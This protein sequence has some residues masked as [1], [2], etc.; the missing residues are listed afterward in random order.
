M[1]NLDN[2]MQN[3][4]AA[5]A[6]FVPAANLPVQAQ[7]PQNAVAPHRPT[8]DDMSENS[9]IL[10]DEYILSKPEGLKI[11]RDMK[12]LLDSFDVIID[13][14]EV[15]PIKQVRANSGGNTTF[16]KSY[17]GVTTDTGA[18]L[19][20]E[21]DRLTRSHE[22]VDGPYNSVEIPVT[23]MNDVKDPKSTLSFPKGT[24]LGYTPSMTGYK[25]FER[26]MK[27]VKKSGRNLQETLNVRLHAE[28]K[29][30]ANNN[31]WGV[32]RFELLAD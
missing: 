10:V 21:I 15:C 6:N 12:G 7:T 14:T 30:N 22:K 4:E 28:K 32:I 2:V 9:G 8:L 24:E 11:S 23:L 16:V 3:A 26:F 1:N 25:E 29:T 27:A 5:A 13:M 20:A 31:E 19:Y 17:D 18:N